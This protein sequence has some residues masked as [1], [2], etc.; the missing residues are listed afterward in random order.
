MARS[1]ASRSLG[2]SPAR[3]RVSQAVRFWRT[4]RRTLVPSR[5]IV[6]PTRRRS[7]LARPRDQPGVFEP[8]QV[9][10]HRG[11]RDALQLGER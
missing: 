4:E 6:S 9:A 8:L 1:I 5:V 7:A 11:R 3:R 10:G 2:V